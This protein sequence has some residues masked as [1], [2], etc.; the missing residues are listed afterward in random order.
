[1]KNSQRTAPDE[2]NRLILNKAK[3]MMLAVPVKDRKKVAM[4]LI[5]MA[6]AKKRAQA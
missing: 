2:Q 1:M 3:G 5:K 4:G 6:Q